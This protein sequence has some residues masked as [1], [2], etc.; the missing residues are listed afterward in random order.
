MAAEKDYEFWCCA[1]ETKIEAKNCKPFCSDRQKTVK[2]F[3]H[4]RKRKIAYV[5]PFNA[6]RTWSWQKDKLRR[7]KT[8][9]G[10]K[11]RDEARQLSHKSRGAKFL[12][13][14]TSLRRHL[15]LISVK[16]FALKLYPFFTNFLRLK[17]EIFH[18]EIRHIAGQPLD[19]WS[20]VWPRKCQD[21][22]GNLSGGSSIK[23]GHGSH[24]K[25][26]T[27]SLEVFSILTP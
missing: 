25:L 12:Q 5:Q 10:E 1:N 15:S 20:I 27:F 14:L 24:Y 11:R 2:H 21:E 17:S 22:K 13:Q 8:R 26:W 4:N 9:R 16:G 23:Q 6:G 19:K 18:S 3:L 7:G